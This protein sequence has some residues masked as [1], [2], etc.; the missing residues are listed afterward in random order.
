MVPIE[1]RLSEGLGILL[2]ILGEGFGLGSTKECKLRGIPYIGVFCCPDHSMVCR[3]DLNQ[4]FLAS[5]SKVALGWWGEWILGS[6]HYAVGKA[7]RLLMGFK[8]AVHTQLG[9][10]MPL[11]KSD[12]TV[13]VF[14]PPT[15]HGLTKQEWCK[16]SV[17]FQKKT[18][19]RLG[20]K[21][22]EDWWFKNIKENGRD[23]VQLA[24]GHLGIHMDLEV[25]DAWRFMDFEKYSWALSWVKHSGAVFNMIIICPVRTLD[26]FPSA[27]KL[28]APVTHH[29]SIPL[30]CATCL[31]VLS[32][33][34]FF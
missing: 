7:F 8:W 5:L 33:F 10:K 6:A 12:N 34:F 24:M 31:S 3:P 11:L 14:T 13:Y 22:I 25:K 29:I 30:S 1:V 32:F 15:V 16:N 27:L 18:S 26:W 2:F 9:E 28:I 21:L 19:Y 23:A 4:F 20:E 17:F